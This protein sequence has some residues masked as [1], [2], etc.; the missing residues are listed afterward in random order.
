MTGI[1][2]GVGGLM[3]LLPIAFILY[4]SPRKKKHPDDL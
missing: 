2:L 3:C 4:F 1:I